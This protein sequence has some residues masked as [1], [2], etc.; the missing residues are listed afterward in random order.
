MNV[1]SRKEGPGSPKS[2][3]RAP[4]DTGKRASA[5][6][7]ATVRALLQELDQLT[8]S[9]RGLEDQLRES[10]APDLER[11]RRRRAEWLVRRALRQL[12]QLGGRPDE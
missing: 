5:P 4:D 7:S 12:G 6:A 1:E 10:P 3:R 2:R 11:L 8:A 9:L